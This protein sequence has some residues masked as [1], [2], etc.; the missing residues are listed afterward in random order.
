MPDRVISVPQATQIAT[1]IKNKFDKVNGRLREQDKVTKTFADALKSESENIAVNRNDSDFG[2]GGFCV[3]DT[4]DYAVRRGYTKDDGVR[5]FP[6]PSIVAP[7]QHDIPKREI[8]AVI[9]SYV[10]RTDVLY[11]DIDVPASNPKPGGLFAETIDTDSGGNHY[12]NCNM[13]AGAVVKGIKYE[14]S[15]YVIDHNVDAEYSTCRFMPESTSPYFSEGWLNTFEIAQYFAEQKQL[16]YTDSDP[17]TAASR[18]QFGDLLFVSTDSSPYNDRYL[19]LSHVVVVLGTIPNTK[20]VL[21]AECTSSGTSFF[22]E[23]AGHPFINMYTISG[24]NLVFARPNYNIP[25]AESIMCGTGGVIALKPYMVMGALINV[26]SDS[27][28]SQRGYIFNGSKRSASC[29]EYIPVVPGTKLNYTG[30]LSDDG[31]LHI[32]RVVFY[33]E[34]MNYTRYVN[35]GYNGVAT[36]ATVDN[37]ERYVRFMFQVSPSSYAGARAIKLSDIYDFSVTIS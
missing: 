12:M 9:K 4:M 33:D 36:Q 7:V 6:L 23:S 34:S 24:S 17:Y 37:T 15:R 13:F 35:L 2:D 31:N 32:I 19:M 25:Y 14:R 11:G 1:K 30:P 16:F 8:L 10:D 21:V 29:R 28:A 22:D 27:D 26:G 3:F 20:F 18:L 5:I